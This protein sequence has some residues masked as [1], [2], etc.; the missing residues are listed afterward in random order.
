MLIFRQFRTNG[1]LSYIVGCSSIREA[2]IIDPAGDVKDYLDC[3]Q[4]NRLTPSFIVETHTH[5]DHQSIAADLAKI[6]GA[7]IAMGEAYETQRR[8]A[9]GVPDAIKAVVAANCTPVVKRALRDQEKISVGEIPVYFFTTPGH[10]KDS[11]CVYVEGRVLT[12]D[13]LHIGGVGRCDVPGSDAGQLYDSIS[14]KLMACGPDAIIYPGH[15]YNENINST[16]AY[17][18]R[19]NPFLAVK[20]RDDFIAKVNAIGT[21]IKPGMQCGAVAAS[22][23]HLQSSHPKQPPAA[24][25]PSPK[26]VMLTQMAQH[27]MHNANPAQTITTQ[28]LKAELDSGKKPYI[29]DV[30]QP[31]EVV[32]GKVPGAVAI[33][34]GEL[35]ARLDELPQ[36]P[37]TPIVTVCARGGRAATAL[38]YLREVKKY[39]NMRNLIGG[40]MGWVEAGMP[41][42]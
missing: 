42:E 28:D 10:T 35:S 30:R 22:A 40:T 11:I 16:L 13:T 34:L 18:L 12:G 15:D 27:F 1:C 17:E 8:L 5:A 24:A 32:R 20:T 38:L 36:D 23:S 25:G 41:I 14:G 37:D 29:L 2:L 4:E 31:E 39:H 33:P 19:H 7:R 3:L 26:E 21:E 6:T 9:E